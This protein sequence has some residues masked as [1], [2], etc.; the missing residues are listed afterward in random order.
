MKRPLFF[1][2]LFAAGVACSAA[3]APLMVN[4]DAWYFI[5]NRPAEEMTVEGL[6]AHID[7]YAAGVGDVVNAFIGA[8][9]ILDS[10]DFIVSNLLLP[11]GSLVFAL[12]CVTKWG[13][14]FDRFLKIGRAH[15]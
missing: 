10:E 12:F 8:R 4:E 5:G 11:L 15:V 3:R 1:C 2:L 14:G 13:W 9:D 7:R 6:K